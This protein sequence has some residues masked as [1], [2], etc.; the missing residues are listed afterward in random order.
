MQAGRC[1]AHKRN[2]VVAS[3]FLSER[4]FIITLRSSLL[5]LGCLASERIVTLTCTNYYAVPLLLCVH[6]QMQASKMGLWMVRL[7]ALCLKYSDILWGCWSWKDQFWFCSNKSYHLWRD[8]FMNGLLYEGK[9]SSA[10]CAKLV[11]A[12][13]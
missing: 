7:C 8:D 4:D 13:Q 9:H 6:V 10:F 12:L 5:Q 11:I 1:N 3:S 2:L